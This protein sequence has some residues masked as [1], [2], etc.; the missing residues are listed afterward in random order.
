MLLP[1]IAYL[2]ADRL[3]FSGVLAVVTA[4]FFITRYTP[5]VLT[6]ATRLQSV[7]WW[8]TTIFL[9]NVLLYVLL[10]LQLRGLVSGDFF[11]RY[12]WQQ[13]TVDVVAVNAI[14]VG[15]RFAWV[16]RKAPSKAISNR[17][18]AVCV[19]SCSP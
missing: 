16:S 4:G 19:S 12:G 8:E 15:M 3:G 11:T 1:F 7:G 10:G 2:P 6:P 18:D 13:L 17:V 14:V 5:E 9:L